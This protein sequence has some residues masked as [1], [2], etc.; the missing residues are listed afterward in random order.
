VGWQI[1]TLATETAASATISYQLAS[2]QWR[3][4]AYNAARVMIFDPEAGRLEAEIGLPKEFQ[5]RGMPS[6]FESE[7]GRWFLAMLSKEGVLYIWD[8]GLAPASTGAL[9]S[10]L[11][12]G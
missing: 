11:K 3:A 8:V 6:I 12:T 1:R 7:D 9:R 4:L 2:G 10:A 5:P